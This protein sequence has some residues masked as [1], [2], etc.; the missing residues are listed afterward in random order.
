MKKLS[1]LCLLLGLVACHKTGILDPDSLYADLTVDDKA[2][3]YTLKDSLYA[4]M[5]FSYTGIVS[6]YSGGFAN[7]AYRIDNVPG[8][9]T[10]QFNLRFINIPFDSITVGSYPLTGSKSDGSRVTEGVELSWMDPE[11]WEVLEGKYYESEAYL[12]C[13]QSYPGYDCLNNVNETMFMR[14]S[15]AINDAQLIIKK[16]YYKIFESWSCTEDTI[17]P[18]LDLV[19]VGTI[20]NCRLKSSIDTTMTRTLS[21]N[22]RIHLPSQ[23]PACVE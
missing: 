16:A 20:S 10:D 9:I 15:G 14:S 23:R 5:Y 21:G 17:I 3:S 7:D 18:F 6:E 22:F 11:T 12:E 8:S 2:I 13:H 1:L 4:D 19:I